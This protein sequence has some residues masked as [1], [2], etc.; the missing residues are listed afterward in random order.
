MASFLSSLL[1]ISTSSTTTS[2][3]SSAFQP[4]PSPQIVS[5]IQISVENITVFIL[6]RH[7]LY[8]ILSIEQSRVDALSSSMT[9]SMLVLNFK[10][11]QGIVTNDKFIS[12]NDS[13]Q[14]KSKEISSQFLL[15]F[16]IAIVSSFE[17]LH[18]ECGNSDRLMMRFSLLPSSWE[19]ILLAE[20]IVN[21]VW[22]TTV[23][24]IFLE[25][26]RSLKQISG[27][28]EQKTSSKASQSFHFN[29]ETSSPVIIKFHLPRNHVM[30][31]EVPSL[32]IRYMNHIIIEMPQFTASL[33]CHPILTI[34]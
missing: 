15:L 32:H 33:D 7:S 21:L 10:I 6:A 20:S 11:L 3:T 19:V 34:E 18:I 28:F 31:W 5:A 27:L 26:F 1:C 2:S 9:L 8:L 17:F 16:L 23:H 4:H 14:I 12:W 24:I 30:C 13:E 29:I 25:T 22:S